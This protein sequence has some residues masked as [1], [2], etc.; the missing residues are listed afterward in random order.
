MRDTGK[1]NKKTT[2]SKNKAHV[3]KIDHNSV[4]MIANFILDAWS[5]CTSYK[6]FHE[7]WKGKGLKLK[8]KKII[9]NRI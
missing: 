9:L 4:V 5:E 6:L 3:E 7:T 1:Q 2:L 8:T